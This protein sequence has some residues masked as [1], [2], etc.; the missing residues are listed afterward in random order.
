MLPRVFD[1]RSQAAWRFYVSR[2]TRR[3]KTEQRLRGP[4]VLS[5][6]PRHEI[7]NC[8][9]EQRGPQC[10]SDRPHTYIYKEEHGVTPGIRQNGKENAVGIEQMFG[11]Q[12]LSVAAVATD[13]Q[14]RR[15]TTRKR[16]CSVEGLLTDS[17]TRIVCAN[18]GVQNAS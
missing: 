11:V 1:S 7:S 5:I 4:V 16:M 8:R 18:E 13:C 3:A 15:G 14:R 12:R 6:I 2:T 10:F 17:N 9:A